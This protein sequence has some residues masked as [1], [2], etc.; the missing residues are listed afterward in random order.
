MTK[1]HTLLQL[2][3]VIGCCLVVGLEITALSSDGFRHHGHFDWTCRRPLLFTPIPSLCFLLLRNSSLSIGWSRFVLSR[4]E[5]VNDRR[6]YCKIIDATLHTWLG[7]L[8]GD[9]VDR[10]PTLVLTFFRSSLETLF[11]SRLDGLTPVDSAVLEAV[12]VAVVGLVFAVL[13]G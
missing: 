8:G 2:S 11:A 9:G 13:A 10:V 1:G 6:Q 4:R 12:E 5:I 7:V 3:R